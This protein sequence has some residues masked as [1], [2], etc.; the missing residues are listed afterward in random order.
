M[1]KLENAVEF[2]LEDAEMV[3]TIQ[4][5]HR[6]YPIKILKPDWAEPSL[7][8]RFLCYIHKHL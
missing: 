3:D 1:W 7:Y 5:E 8:Q 6:A 4:L 2:A